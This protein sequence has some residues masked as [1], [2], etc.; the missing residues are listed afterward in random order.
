MHFSRL[1]RSYAA[2]VASAPPE[3]CISRLGVYGLWVRQGAKA[4][5]LAK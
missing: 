4:L 2:K 3:G 5:T 1:V